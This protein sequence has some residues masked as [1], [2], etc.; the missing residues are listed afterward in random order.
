MRAALTRLWRLLWGV[1]AL[2]SCWVF[3]L[4][5]FFWAG[6]YLAQC[7]LFLTSPGQPIRVSYATQTGVATAEADSYTV[8]IA[9]RR[10]S[11][12]GLRV[13]EP[14]GI[15]ALAAN[16]IGVELRGI[17]T[18]VRIDRLTARVDRQA[19]GGLALGGI[20]PKEDRRRDESGLDIQ[21]G[22]LELDYRDATGPG[23]DRRLALRDLTLSEGNG[24]LIAAASLRV[25]GKPEIPLRMQF[26]KGGDRFWLEA[27][28][29]GFDAAPE[30]DLIRS[31]LP[32]EATDPWQGVSAGRLVLTG[33]IRLAAEPGQAPQIWMDTE[34]EAEAAAMKGLFEPLSATGKL[35]LDPEAIRFDAK[36]ARP[37]L[38]VEI[39]GSLTFAT[40][41]GQA[42]A[43]VLAAG[44]GSLDPQWRQLLPRGSSFR[45]AKFTGRASWN[46][47]F[48]PDIQGSF[49]VAEAAYEG[50]TLRRA[51]GLLRL[52]PKGLSVRLTKGETL[53]LTASGWLDWQFQ[54]DRLSGTFATQRGNLRPLL[55]R[56]TTARASGVGQAVVVLGGTSRKPEA[57][58]SAQGDGEYTFDPKQEPLRLRGIEVRAHLDSERAK[59]DRLTFRND[60]GFFSLLGSMRWKDQALDLQAEAMGIQLG[61]IRNDLEGVGYVQG[62]ING[63]LSK[64]VALARAEVYG[65]KAQGQEADIVM[66][67]IAASFQQVSFMNVQAQ[68]GAAR[69]E[70]AGS[71][72]VEDDVLS[73]AFQA[74]NILLADWTNQQVFGTAKA[75]DIQLTGSLADPKVRAVVEGK[76]ITVGGVK[77]DSGSAQLQLNLQGLEATEARL[78]LGDGSVTGSGSFTFDG[79]TLDA[80]FESVN[81]PV[82]RVPTDG[83]LALG[84]V[85]N[86][87]GT[88]RH[89]E[90]QGFTALFNGQTNR[91]EVN[92][93]AAG[94][95]QVTASLER[96][97]LTASAQIGSLERF[98][99]LDELKW[100]LDTQVLAAKAE[101]FNFNLD[102]VTQA[103]RGQLR[104]LSDPLR[105]AAEGAKGAISGAIEVS[106]SSKDLDVSLTGV[107]VAGLEI[108]GR[109]AGQIRLTGARKSGSWSFAEAAWR[110]GE[111]AL[112]L[113]DAA[114][115]KDGEVSGIANL[116]RFDLGWIHALLPE[117]PQLQGLATATA[118]ASGKWD[119]PEVQA[120]V[121]I[122]QGGVV[123]RSGDEAGESVVLFDS[124]DFTDFSISNRLATASGLVR[125]R[126][127]TGSLQARV[128]F[129][130]FAEPGQERQPFSASLRLDERPL[131]DF[132]DYVAAFRDG[133]IVGKAS[134]QIAVSGLPDDLRIQGSLKASA[135][136]VAAKGTSDF[137]P[138]TSLKDVGAELTF[139]EKSARLAGSL[140]SSQGGKISFNLEA[141]QGELF[142]R[143]LRALDGLDSWNEFLAQTALKGEIV[144]EAFSLR[145]KLPK[146]DQA[147]LATLNGRVTFGGDLDRPRIGGAL[148]FSGVDFVLPSE[149]GQGGPAGEPLIDPIFDNLRL[150][151]ALGSRIRFGL[152]QLIVNG[153]GTL[154]GPLS[155]LNV[156]APLNVSQGQLRLP[157][158]RIEI[159][160]GGRLEIGYRG[161]VTEN[162]VRVD[163]DLEGLTRV[164]ARRA[165]D[166]YENYEVRLFFRGSLLNPDGLRIDAISDPPDLSRDEVLAIL[167]QRQLFE[168][169]AGSALGRQ[170]TA[171]LLDPLYQLALPS[172]TQGFTSQLARSFQLDY[173]SLDYNP[174]DQAVIRAGKSLNRAFILQ[175]SRQL[176][177]PAFG[178]PKYEI[179]LTYRL[180]VRDNV[181]GRIRVG[182][183]TDQDRP[184]K[185]TLDW[186][187]R[188]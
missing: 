5:L 157:N 72:L 25:D 8:D 77:I 186:A 85:L 73:G 7:A 176:V 3:P 40:G 37:G 130:A 158:A 81:L 12:F 96:G 83:L 22:V 142:E 29:N 107:S 174:F 125:S 56:F 109:D 159:E 43:T 112:I 36:A 9:Q 15:Q 23:R 137:Q 14:G 6:A 126:G 74:S 80:A 150:T 184:W 30:L 75:S 70:G 35:W 129:S 133:L 105:E 172:L 111:S 65:L 18:A 102:D 141:G 110:G 44:P 121:S 108:A 68:V 144:S 188:W 79:Q 118:Q 122:S 180:P 99:R 52:D 98:V 136:Q 27:R 154:A 167:G 50:E 1:V 19:D 168:A 162:P 16:R 131:A 140:L 89:N 171:A 183:G 156:R 113:E 91:L 138:E 148:A 116:T 104:G 41:A 20:L 173:V 92:D 123:T 165:L 60:Y 42:G 187:R 54:P 169:L 33:D 115:S 38:D 177:E 143:A 160:D 182:L 13:I 49:Q 146:S 117:T 64:P 86:G 28:P 139:D 94:A 61:K 57:V 45:Q 76:D 166:Q 90:D 17:A 53:G 178:K 181:L 31:W 55:A 95:G 132:G 11:I 66:A 34:V 153:E 119:N 46:S 97:V 67:D 185:L 135:D 32:K 47:K 124:L 149:F 103:L 2:L 71:W 179:K 147:S 10:V 84:G 145:Q 170:G 134:G 106:G 161:G 164:T 39:K 21:V 82:S 59:L 100:N 163:V 24:S 78:V 155:A 152:G 26:G 48:Q 101:V 128:P 114:L 63:T 69:V 87:K 51:D 4:L 127:L 62:S 175:G 58:A 88:L 151:A 120:S 93:T